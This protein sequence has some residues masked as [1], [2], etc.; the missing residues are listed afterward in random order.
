MLI[1]G[2]T[3]ATLTVT[4]SGSYSVKVSAIDGSLTSAQIESEP[5]TCTVNPVTE[6]PGEEPGEDNPGL[7]DPDNGGDARRIAAGGC[8]GCCGSRSGGSCLLF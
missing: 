8:F 7:E 2:Q 1:E 6:E 4:E 3:G 5:V